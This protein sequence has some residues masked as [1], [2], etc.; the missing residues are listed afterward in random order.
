M[1]K[2]NVR[3]MNRKAELLRIQSKYLTMADQTCTKILKHFFP[4][5]QNPMQEITQR[6][7][8]LSKEISDNPRTIN[9][10]LITVESPVDRTLSNFTRVEDDLRH[11]VKL[12]GT[13]VYK[14]VPL[15][16]P[17]FDDD[18]GK[19]R[20]SKRLK[21]TQ[22]QAEAKSRYKPSQIEEKENFHGIS[23]MKLSYE[24]DSVDQIVSQRQKTKTQLPR[25]ESRMDAK[26]DLTL[27][28][29][30]NDTSFQIEDSCY[31]SFER[32]GH[33]NMEWH[34]SDEME[35]EQDF[36]L[37][38]ET[39]CS[40]IVDKDDDS[41]RT[42]NKSVPWNVRFINYAKANETPRSSNSMSS[43]HSFMAPSDISPFIF[44]QKQTKQPFKLF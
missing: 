17:V 5:N 23:S 39:K 19:K 44:S 4:N 27:E 8:R 32:N 11:R 2:V 42:F 36:E 25:Q 43:L 20:K 35:D 26:L 38:N 18:H 12:P 34:D 24:M 37:A 28:D 7:K 21:A 15:A 1:P 22:T 31:T 16:L 29:V 14:F 30:H 3:E 40:S 41:P 10:T 6:L 33:D 13:P 9:E